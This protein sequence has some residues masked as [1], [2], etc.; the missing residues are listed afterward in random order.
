MSLQA[1]LELADKGFYVFPC[2]RYEKRPAVTDWESKATTDKEQITKWFS[3]TTGR[4]IGVACGPSNLVV[5]DIDVKNDKMGLDRIDELQEEF[6]DLPNTASAATPSGGL[7]YYFRALE[8][9]QARSTVSLIAEGIDTRAGGGYVVA[10]GSETAEGEYQWIFDDEL[11]PCPEWIVERT[12]VSSKPPRTALSGIQL[13]NALDISCAVEYLEQVPHATQGQGGDSH[14]YNV[15]CH[16]HDQGISIP[17]GISL[18]LEHWNPKCEPPWEP[19][20]IETKMSNAYDFAQ[21]EPGCRSLQM[22]AIK[23]APKHIHRASDINPAMPVRDWLIEGR[24]VSGYITLT[25][26][27]GG[28]G[29]SMYTMLEAISVATGRPLTGQIPKRRGAV[30]I[31]NTED[32]QDEIERRLLAIA[33]HYEIPKEEM[34][35]IFYASGIESPLRFVTNDGVRV[36]TDD[37]KK[38]EQIV[39]DNE[40]VLTVIDP[41]VRAHTVDENN[42]GDIDMVCQQMSQLAMATGSAVSIVHHTRKTKDSRDAGSMDLARGASALVSA[43]RIV[44]TLL[45]PTE[46]ECSDLGL[47]ETARYRYV[48]LDAA[49]GNMAPRTEGTT[50]FEKKSVIIPNGESVGTLEIIKIEENNNGGISHTDR[51]RRNRMDAIQE[52]ERVTTQGV[53]GTEA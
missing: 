46:D 52:Q 3:H 6:G 53:E 38:L 50:W 44:S 13:D 37:R 4:N 48:R 2:V 10:P 12:K 1:A 29:K 39:K 19:E 21:S 31:Y 7:H 26:A 27:P 41:F 42:N 45:G 11:A 18:M 32:P 36:I 15:C 34:E 40:I 33:Q 5:L 17:M 35:N 43:A 30:L 51:Q 24:L 20:E 8:H 14:T 49:K 23:S 9:T 28:V 22:G 47:P 25:L 16:L